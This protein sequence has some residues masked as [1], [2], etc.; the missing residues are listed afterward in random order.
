[1]RFYG[2]TLH[3]SLLLTPLSTIDVWPQATG[4]TFI[5]QQDDAAPPVRLLDFG[6]G[7]ASRVGSWGAP[8]PISQD[9]RVISPE[10]TGVTGLSG[11]PAAAVPASAAAMAGA[12]SVH[13]GVAG[14]GS[15]ITHL[16]S[17]HT[18]VSSTM[19]SGVVAPHPTGV[20]FM[21]AATVPRIPGGF[22]TSHSPHNAS[23][24]G[25]FNFQGLPPPIKENPRVEDDGAASFIGAPTRGVD[26]ETSSNHPAAAKSP[27]GS[28][29]AT[30]VGASSPKPPGSPI[31]KT[32]QYAREP[33]SGELEAATP[34]GKTLSDA[35]IAESRGAA[36][37]D[38]TRAFYGTH[39]PACEFVFVQMALTYSLKCPACYQL[40]TVCLELTSRARR[41][42][43]FLDGLD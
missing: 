30:R 27:S 16:P 15:T 8:L 5:T 33:P 28:A 1:V 22:K 34:K 36:L 31:S 24:A 23:A 7:D 3:M 26:A 32:M 11:G 41:E 13:G 21:S 25:A 6:S 2:G 10:P 39:R 12:S 38:A 17:M 42:S 9:P 20:T 19:R 40:E 29:G 43:I 4:T 18:G 14:P 35:T 37:V